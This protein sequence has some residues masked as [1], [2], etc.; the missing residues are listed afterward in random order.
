MAMKEGI[1][2]KNVAEM[3]RSDSRQADEEIKV[4]PEMIEAG[5]EAFAGYDTR[6]EGPGDIVGE[7]FIAMFSASPM[8]QILGHAQ[9]VRASEI[10]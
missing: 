2:T 4:T 7:I 10:A 1:E 9:K 3:A 6:F 5:T 8:A